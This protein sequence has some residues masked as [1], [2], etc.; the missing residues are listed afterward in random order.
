[1]SEQEGVIRYQCNLQPAGFEWPD[2]LLAGLNL[3]RSRMMQKGWMGQDPARYGG[4]GFGNLSLRHATPAHPQAFIITASQTGHLTTLTSDGWPLVIQAS[5]TQNSI[6][7]LGSHSPSSE[8]L[9]HAA[10]YQSSPRIK[11]VIHIHCPDLWH[12]ALALKLTAT[13]RQITYGTPAMASAI[14]EQIHTPQGLLVMQGHQDGLLAW[15][16]DLRTAA[17]QLQH[18]QDH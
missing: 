3:W 10:V 11:A 13:A 17:A 16:P 5:T 18:L 1:M 8:A 6:D 14:H 4:L 2:C 15:G 9:S 12:K 7:A